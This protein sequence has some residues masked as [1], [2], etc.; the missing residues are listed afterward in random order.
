MDEQIVG[1]VAGVGPY[2]G[3]DMQ[4]KIFDQTEAQGDT[5]H[6]T[7][8]GWYQSSAVPDRTKFLLGE[9]SENPGYA[10]A[11]QLLK[12]EKAGASV[13]AIPC[14]TAHAPPIFDVVQNE[15]AKQNSSLT[16]LHMIHEVAHHLKAQF[17]TIECVGV[18]STT[19]TFDTKIYPNILEPLGYKVVVPPRD[20]QEEHVNPTIY[21]PLYGI[22]ATGIGTEVVRQTLFETISLLRTAGAQAII[23]GCTEL[24]L[25]IVEAEIDGLPMIDPTVT[26]A[27]AV[28]HAVNPAKLRH[29]RILSPS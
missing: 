5:D 7:V 9:S 10:I 27:R 11:E 18:L 23:L 19:G 15:L 17:D 22:K 24:P 16:L 20:W 6:L 1:I 3:L 25:A 26:L 21:D 4:R 13:A 28:I 8:I 2:A 29:P 14:N 12:L